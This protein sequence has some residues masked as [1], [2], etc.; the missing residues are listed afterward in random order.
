[1]KTSLKILRKWWMMSAGGFSQYIIGGARSSLKVL[2]TFDCNTDQIAQDHLDSWQ[3]QQT[4]SRWLRYHIQNAGFQINVFD[5][6]LPWR[7]NNPSWW[8]TT[9]QPTT[10]TK[11]HQKSEEVRRRTHYWQYDNVQRIKNDLPNIISAKIWS[12][13]R[14]VW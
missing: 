12:Y 14:Q 4:L 3:I 5:R 13:S 9:A 8:S 11:L 2:L 10:N 1:M 6:Q 7:Q